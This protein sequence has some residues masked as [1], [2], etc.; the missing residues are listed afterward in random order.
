MEHKGSD[1]PDN[2]RIRVK[3]TLHPRVTDWLGDL[4]ILPQENGESILEGTFTD[5]PALRGILDQLWDL[6][7]T[8]IS[9]ER[10]ENE[11]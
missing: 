6:N 8:V 3:E 7:I 10:I 2:Y 11:S 5:Q 1:H 9:V 4:T